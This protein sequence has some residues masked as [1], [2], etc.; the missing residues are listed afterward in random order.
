MT[1][2]TATLLSLLTLLL[3]RAAPAETML[4]VAGGRFTVDGRPTFLLGVSYYGTLGAPDEFVRRDLDDFRR[5]GFNWVRVWA[6]WA[7]FGEDVSAVGDGLPRQP[8]LDR[9]VKLVRACDE[10][11]IVVDVSLSRQN[12]VS[13]GPRLQSLEHHRRTVETLVGAL[14]PHRNWYLDL[15]N[16]RNIRDARFTPY[17]DLKQLRDRVRELDP[18]RLVTASHSSDDESF[19]DEI[20]KYVKTVGVD[21]LSPHRPREPDSA[22]QT[23]DATRQFIR[24]MG[25]L[26]RVVPVHYQEPFRRGYARWQPSADDYL[27]DLRGAIA[28][29]A[30]GWCFHNGDQRDAS[31]GRPRRS[32]DLREKRLYDQLDDVERAVVRQLGPVVKS[33]TKRE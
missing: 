30:A 13:G 20:E 33:A 10:R 25:Q 19:A 32:F 27:H 8:Y 2:R 31:D 9:L 6:T 3:A 7:A 29:G 17:E 23:E 14:R 28:G 22:A 15:S 18:G 5:D 26:G 4:G 24:R 11:G 12:G 1:S 16:E 21:F